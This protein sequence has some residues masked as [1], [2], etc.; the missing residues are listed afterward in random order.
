MPDQGTQ[1]TQGTQGAPTEGQA[2]QGGQVAAPAAPAAPDN[3]QAQINRAVAKA[4]AEAKRELG[5]KLTAAE[6]E[7]LAGKAAREKLAELEAKEQTAVEKAAKALENERRMAAAREAELL[8]TVEAT[9]A[10][11]DKDAI[12]AA[13]A[14]V[15]AAKVPQENS[16]NVVQKDLAEGCKRKDDGTV[17]W[18]DPETDQELPPDKALEAYLAANPVF[19][20]A[21][22]SGSGATPGRPPGSSRKPI[23]QMSKAELK[24][25]ADRELAG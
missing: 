9:K 13:L 16:P 5:E 15:V 22:V 6:A 19:A 4:V 12:N 3:V 25:E 20:I 7:A 17:V 8:K 2:T 1:G 18:I 11:A 14:K 24:A 23:G 10:R 21:P